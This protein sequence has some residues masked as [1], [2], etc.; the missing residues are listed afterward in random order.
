MAGTI[1]DTSIYINSLRKNDSSVL[2][3]R[4][5]SSEQNENEPLFLS[6]VVLEELYVGA[7]N[8]KLKKLLAKF[9]KDFEKI[10][11]LLVPNQTDWTICGQVLSAIGQKYG[12]E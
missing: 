8:R 11:R 3:Q 9:E 12:F 10:N 6:A 4:R 1:F 5:T 2:G 7:V